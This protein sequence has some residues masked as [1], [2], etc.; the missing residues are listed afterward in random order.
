[1]GQRGH[2]D[3]PAVGRQLRPADYELVSV[4]T[5]TRSLETSP[6]TRASVLNAKLLE[7]TQL[8]GRDIN[9]GPARRRFGV[10]TQSDYDDLTYL[11]QDPT[12]GGNAD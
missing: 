1:M 5:A 8:I 4:T 10:A 9:W 3:R 11:A 7:S 12:E 6:Q 2:W